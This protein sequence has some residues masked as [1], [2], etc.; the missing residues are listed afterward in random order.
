MEFFLGVFV[1]GFVVGGIMF[2]KMM[3]AKADAAAAP[4]DYLTGKGKA[5]APTEPVEI[6]PITNPGESL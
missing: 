5:V 1:G 4:N 6:D 3:A 2:A